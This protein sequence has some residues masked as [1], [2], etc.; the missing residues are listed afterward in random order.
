MAKVAQEARK[1][2]PD[3]DDPEFRTFLLAKMEHWTKS[4]DDWG[5]PLRPAN[6][7]DG[8]LQGGSAAD[9]P[10]LA[11]RQG[12]QRRQDAGPRRDPA[13][14]PDLGPGELRPGRS[15]TRCPGDAA[16]SPRRSSPRPRP[17]E[18][19]FA[20]SLTEDSN[21]TAPRREAVGRRSPSRGANRALLESAVRPGR[22]L[23]RRRVRLRPVRPR[24]VAPGRS[25]PRVS[26]LH[27]VSTFGSEIDS[28]FVII[29]WITGI[30]FI[31]TQVALVW[32]T[33]KFADG[34]GRVAAVLPRQP[35][36]GGDLDDHPG[37]DPGL[38]RPLPDG[39]LGERQVPSSAR[40][41][42][43]PWPRSPAGS[44]SG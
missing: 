41:R 26:H 4:L 22:A 3:L 33:W 7:N 25:R 9:R 23:L 5:N 30:V 11:D 10:L 14:R 1:L 35:A 40:P 34:P 39:D 29:L 31:G 27:S 32:A 42:S 15:A 13:R 36:A 19:R 38:H 2:L 28:L 43:R 37:G 6:L 24:L 17:A 18:R 16:R 8:A 21:P 12:D 44:S 20:A